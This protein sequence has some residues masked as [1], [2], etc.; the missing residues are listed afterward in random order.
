MAHQFFFNPFIL[1]NL[2]TPASGF[3]VVQDLS[4]P[5][6]RMYVTSRGVKTFFVRKR[7]RGRDRRIIIGNYPDMDIETA[8]GA[9]P[10]ILATASIAPR[11]HRKKITLKKFLDI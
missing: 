4:E 7:V 8:R 11:V 5:R 10:E 1:D 6:L 3:D 2:P 9:V